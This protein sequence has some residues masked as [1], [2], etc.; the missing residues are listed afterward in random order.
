MAKVR[1]TR[2]GFYG[3]LRY[4]GD[5]FDV[6]D[7]Q[8]AR[9]WSWVE[10]LEAPAADPA[11]APKVKVHPAK[12]REAPKPS[13]IVPGDAPAIPLAKAQQPSEPSNPPI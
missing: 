10:V 4:P 13:D 3:S 11:P 5:E 12:G 1:A 9:A 2:I 8:F 6:P 7:E